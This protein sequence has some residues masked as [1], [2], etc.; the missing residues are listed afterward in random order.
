MEVQ[1]VSRALRRHLKKIPG[2][3]RV[4]I[5]HVRLDPR[6]EPT[7]EALVVDVYTTNDYVR[8]LDPIYDEKGRIVEKYN[9]DVTA[10]RLT[11]YPSR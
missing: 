1:K 5:M 2:V 3:Q 7:S 8:L 11:V 4:R 6:I 9:I 10:V